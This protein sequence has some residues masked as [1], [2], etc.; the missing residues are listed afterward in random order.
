MLVNRAINAAMSDFV[1]PEC[2]CLEILNVCLF[3]M[4]YIYIYTYIS[5]RDMFLFFLGNVVCEINILFDK[6][7]DA[8]IC[9]CIY[10]LYMYIYIYIYICIYLYIFHT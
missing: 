7:M 1:R 3:A 10:I 6:L 9:M 2:L 4:R 8:C 5:W